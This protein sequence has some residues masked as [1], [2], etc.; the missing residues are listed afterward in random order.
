VLS[1]F[2]WDPGKASRN[3]IKH[4]VA[5]EDAALIWSAPLL[6]VVHTDRG[7]DGTIRIVSA[8]KATRNE[9]RVYE[10]GDF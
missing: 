6:P 7:D 10:N 2:L 8:R 3:L 5:F 9:R 4:G 1:Q